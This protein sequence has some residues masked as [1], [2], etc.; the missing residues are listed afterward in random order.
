MI[1]IVHVIRLLLYLNTIFH[2]QNIHF[3]RTVIRANGVD[4]LGIY[5]TFMSAGDTFIDI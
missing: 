4:T 5:I 2:H 3:T 1:I